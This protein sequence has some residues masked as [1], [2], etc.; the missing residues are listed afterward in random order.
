MRREALGLD[1]RV[2][3]G[4]DPRSAAHAQEAD[5]VLRQQSYDHVIAPL[6]G[7]SNTHCGQLPVCS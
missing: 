5:E 2:T 7:L 6:V 4:Q 1:H 3:V